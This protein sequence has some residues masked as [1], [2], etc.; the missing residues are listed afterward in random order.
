LSLCACVRTR[1]PC[2]LRNGPT[3]NSPGFSRRV[4][5][6]GRGIQVLDGVRP[7]TPLPWPLGMPQARESAVLPWSSLRLRGMALLHVIR[8]AAIIRE[9]SALGCL[10]GLSLSCAS[11][12]E[13]EPRKWR[14]LIP[15]LSPKHH[16]NAIPGVKSGD[17]RESSVCGQRRNTPALH[18]LPRAATCDGQKAGRYDPQYRPGKPAWG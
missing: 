8:K 15:A 16:Q 17:A 6:G 5:S 4:S 1:L 7:V 3:A 2:S 11:A 10:P 13:V 14:S 18:R 12:P 9:A